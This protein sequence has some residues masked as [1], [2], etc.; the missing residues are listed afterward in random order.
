MKKI[1]CIPCEK[2]QNP[3]TSY[4]WNKTLVLSWAKYGSTNEKIFEKCIK[5]LKILGLIDNIN[6]W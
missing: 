4:S 6:E 1:Y 2:Y 3:K 5:M